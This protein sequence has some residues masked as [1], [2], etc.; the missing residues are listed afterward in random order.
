M[1]WHVSPLREYRGHAPLKN[2]CGR[3]PSPPLH[4]AQTLSRN[5]PPFFFLFICFSIRLEYLFTYRRVENRKEGGENRRDVIAL[6]FKHIFYC[7]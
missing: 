1:I 6:I 4:C 7:E 3:A 5:A 2:I